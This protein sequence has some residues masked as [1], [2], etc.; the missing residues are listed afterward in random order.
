MTLELFATLTNLNIRSSLPEIPALKFHIQ[1]A[2][3]Y[4]TS[5]YPAQTHINTP[6]QPAEARD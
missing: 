2:R 3:N 6:K 5:S 4:L 1:F